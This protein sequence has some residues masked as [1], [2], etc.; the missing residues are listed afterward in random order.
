MKFVIDS[1]NPEQ[2]EEVATN[3]GKLLKGGEIIEL[4][5]ELGSGK[6][7]FTHGL[8]LGV[9]SKD[10]VASPTFTISRVYNGTYLDIYHFDFYR[11]QDVDLIAH[12]LAD[13]VRNPKNIA[14]IEWAEKLTKSLPKERLLIEFKYLD[15]DNRKLLFTCPQSLSYLVNEYVDTSN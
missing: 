8:A 12:E 14:V 11:L 15:E 9:G 10:K 4:S 6:T 1:K 13:V 5:G 7:T 3:I 2:T